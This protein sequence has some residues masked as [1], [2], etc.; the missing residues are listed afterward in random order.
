[1]KTVLIDSPSTPVEDR[2]A[3][4]NFPDA[5]PVVDSGGQSGSSGSG[6]D[7]SDSGDQSGGSNDSSQAFEGWVVD[8][9]YELLYLDETTEW[10]YSETFGWA[11]PSPSADNGIWFFLN[12]TR[13]WYWSQ[14]TS[15]PY[16]YDDT[17]GS[18][19]YLAEN[20]GIR[21]LYDFSLDTWLPISE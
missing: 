10:I 11:Y 12:D 16:V 1:M 7:S 21:F 8:P 13:T 19:K 18:F 17:D 6:Q 5:V 20:N 14:D 15:F 3:F 2:P 9:V 4:D